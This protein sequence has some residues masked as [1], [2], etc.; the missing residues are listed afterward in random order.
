MKREE[1][2]KKLLIE[3][4]YSKQ[5][6]YPTMDLKELYIELAQKYVNSKKFKYVGEEHKIY[7]V[8]FAYEDCLKHGL[9]FRPE[10]SDQAYN[11]ILQIIGCSFAKAFRFRFKKEVCKLSDTLSFLN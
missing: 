8:A 2:N 1:F 11:Y 10:R 6:G 3:L 7:F 9:N 5:K 4:A